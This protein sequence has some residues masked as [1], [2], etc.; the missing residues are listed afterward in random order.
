[1]EHSPYSQLAIGGSLGDGTSPST[2]TSPYVT[3]LY[4]QAEFGA[5]VYSSLDGGKMALRDSGSSVCAAAAWS[6]HDDGV[7][8]E[9]GV[10]RSDG[11]RREE[12]WL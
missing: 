10:T 8:K 7:K 3:A 9:S 11:V 5:S 2:T 4:G 6:G 1:M 12:E